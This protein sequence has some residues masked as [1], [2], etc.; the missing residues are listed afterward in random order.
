MFV[1]FHWFLEAP[2]A[3][4]E[5]VVH[6]EPRTAPRAFGAYGAR[7]YPTPAPPST[8]CPGHENDQKNKKSSVEENKE[9]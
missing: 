7:T 3:S 5:V 9:N 1:D 4:G 2:R 8:V 6:R